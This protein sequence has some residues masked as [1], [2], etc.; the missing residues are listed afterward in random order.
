[1]FGQ[2]AAKKAPKNGESPNVGKT[3][4][5][6]PAMTGNGNHTHKNGD[7]IILYTYTENDD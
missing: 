1:M 6:A 4:P 7:Y 5:L 2:S 3:M